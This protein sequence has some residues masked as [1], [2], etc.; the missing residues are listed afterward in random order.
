[1]VMFQ[2]RQMLKQTNRE[3]EEA[4]HEVALLSEKALAEE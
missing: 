3:G 1:M 4:R 2:G